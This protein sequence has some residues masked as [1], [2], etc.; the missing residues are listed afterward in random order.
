MSFVL[1]VHVTSMSSIFFFFIGS[2]SVF[3]AFANWCQMPHGKAAFFL[4]IGWSGRKMC[5]WVRSAVVE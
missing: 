2:N 5:M 1:T 4:N 3:V